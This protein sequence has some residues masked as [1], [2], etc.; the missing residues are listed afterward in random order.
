[1]SRRS[2]WRPK[3]SE[4]TRA[5]VASRQARCQP[6]VN[7]WMEADTDVASRQARCQP[8]V[9]VRMETDTGSGQARCQPKINFVGK[10]RR[11][12]RPGFELN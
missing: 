11:N 2:P 5:G 3:V 9:N 6:K 7:I 10:Q 4:E 8:K 12:P 1:M